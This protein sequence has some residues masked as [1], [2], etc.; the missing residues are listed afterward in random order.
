MSLLGPPVASWD[1]PGR[2][3]APGQAQYVATDVY[4]TLRIG[5]IGEGPTIGTRVKPQ[6]LAPLERPNK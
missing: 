5:A 6:G 4:K 1:L 3:R 2:L